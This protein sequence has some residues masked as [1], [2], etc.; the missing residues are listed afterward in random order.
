M[1]V[2]RSGRVIFF[3]M[4]WI[5]SEEERERLAQLQIDIDGWRSYLITEWNK[6]N[7]SGYDRALSK[8]RF[9]HRVRGEWSVIDGSVDN[10]EKAALAL[11]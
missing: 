11:S 10:Q 3:P 8:A 6:L 4:K 7:L 2:P 1:D 5:P 9:H